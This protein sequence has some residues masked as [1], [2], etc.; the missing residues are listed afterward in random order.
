VKDNRILLVLWT[1]TE[2]QEWSS[3]CRNARSGPGVT[4]PRYTTLHRPPRTFVPSE[5]CCTVRQDAGTGRCCRRDEETSPGY[6][7]RAGHDEPAPRDP[8]PPRMLFYPRSVVARTSWIRLPGGD[9][10]WSSRNVADTPPFLMSS[11]PDGS[12]TFLREL[13]GIQGKMAV[14]YRIKR[15]YLKI[16]QTSK[17]VIQ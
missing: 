3:R 4:S 5:G 8:P 12:R 17:N 16:S 13:T 14:R 7:C 9:S 10:L 11:R 6:P 15:V 2:L 1:R